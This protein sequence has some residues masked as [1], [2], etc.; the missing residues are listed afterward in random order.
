V[1]SGGAT[2]HVTAALVVAVIEEG[3]SRGGKRA[4]HETCNRYCLLK[5]LTT[6][7]ARLGRHGRTRSGA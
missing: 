7:A 2:G 4:G 5:D 6:G 1:A 3:D